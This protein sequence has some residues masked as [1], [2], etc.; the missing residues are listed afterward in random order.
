MRSEA[1]RTSAFLKSYRAAHPRAVCLKRV[2]HPRAEGGHPDAEIFDNG[3]VIQI[4]F[5]VGHP[6]NVEKDVRP[7]QVQRLR[8]Y[9]AAGIPAVVAYFDGPDEWVLRPRYVSTKRGWTWET[10]CGGP[11]GVIQKYVEG[12][13]C[14]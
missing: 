9:I 14:V 13:L 7:L 4:E 12:V 2:A 3:R 6:G 10:L 1:Q 8:Q 11:A 5:K